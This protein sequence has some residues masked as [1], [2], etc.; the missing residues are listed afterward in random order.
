[1]PGAVRGNAVLIEIE[2]PDNAGSWLE[3]AAIEAPKVSFSLNGEEVTRPPAGS[4]ATDRWWAEYLDGGK[5]QMTVSGDFG[6]RAGDAAEFAIDSFV[7]GSGKL[8]MRVDL[9]IYGTFQGV[10]MI[11]TLDVDTGTE[12]KGS[13][14][15]SSDG[16]IVRTPA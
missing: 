5:R 15:L 6:A 3:F 13:I 7:N 4:A 16:E 8:N 12:L 14:Q 9:P 11:N 2:D 1:M 10:W